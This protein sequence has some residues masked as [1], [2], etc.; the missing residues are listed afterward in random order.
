MK[1]IVDMFTNMHK[2]QVKKEKEQRDKKKGKPLAAVKGGG[3]KGYDRNNNAAMV[4]DVMGGDDYGDYGDEGGNFKREA[5][6]DY[7]F[8]W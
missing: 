1:K 2:A 5:E 6:A 3:S 4:N 7:D 8:M